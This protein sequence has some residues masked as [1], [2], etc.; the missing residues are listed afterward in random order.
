MISSGALRPFLSR[1]CKAAARV[2][3]G[4]SC[5]QLAAMVTAP[6]NRFS[7]HRVLYSTTSFYDSQSGQEVFLDERVK[8]NDLAPANMGYDRSLALC[9]QLSFDNVPSAVVAK[10]EHAHW[11]SPGTG[12][13]RVTQP[14]EVTTLPNGCGVLLELPC[15]DNRVN[16]RESAVAIA[17]AA[18]KRG[19]PVRAT[20]LDGFAAGPVMIQLAACELAD[21]GVQQLIVGDSNGLG[22]KETLEGMAEALIEADVEGTPMAYRAGLRAAASPAGMELSRAAVTDFGFKHLDACTLGKEAPELATLV[23]IFDDL[24]IKHGL[25]GTKPIDS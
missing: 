6:R 12:Y 7:S 11:L 10:G 22:D 19:L 4:A 17:S 20:F 25:D 3:P 24:G 16:G 5:K 23:R 21:V 8:L 9:S 14:E 2:A 1:S 18:V 15:E 13:V